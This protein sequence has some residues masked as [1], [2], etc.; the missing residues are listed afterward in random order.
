MLKQSF[1]F[2]AIT[3]FVGIFFISSFDIF[4]FILEKKMA[5]LTK[6]DELLI[7][8]RAI[9]DEIEKQRVVLEKSGIDGNDIQK[10]SLL[11]ASLVT[12]IEE[13]EALKNKVVD[14]E[15]HTRSVQEEFLIAIEKLERS[16][17]YALSQQVE[18]RNAY[19]DLQKSIEKITSLESE[20]MELKA[21][22]AHQREL[23]RN[24]AFLI[25]SGGEI[26]L[27]K[28]IKKKIADAA[29]GKPNIQ[30]GGPKE[31]SN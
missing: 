25:D 15:G 10:V 20:N 1:F 23:L 24:V 31:S 18:T 27:T 30:V 16:N 5:S 13:M 4:A 28:D 9:E 22:E 21:I 3:V 29:D 12:T 19:N 7:S 2:I 11:D 8:S 6:V 14:F 17:S 26:K